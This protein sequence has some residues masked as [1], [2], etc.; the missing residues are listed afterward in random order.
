MAS[1]GTEAKAGRSAALRSSGTTSK[2]APKAFDSRAEEWRQRRLERSQKLVPNQPKRAEKDFLRLE[3]DSFQ[4][5]LN[6]HWKAFYPKTGNLSDGS[7]FSLGLRHFK[8]RLTKA[9]LSVQTSGE[10]SFTGYRLASF[11]FVR[12]TQIAPFLFLGPNELAS[13]FKFGDRQ[14]TTKRSIPL[15]QP[16]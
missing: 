12:F 14:D 10:A 7:S 13:P 5:I 9:N 8:S 16:A 2:E 1:P 15:F 3:S 4:E 11:E 6:I